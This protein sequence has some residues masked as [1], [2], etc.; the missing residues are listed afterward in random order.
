MSSPR[1]S[2]PALVFT[3]LTV[4]AVTVAPDVEPP[5]FTAGDAIRNRNGNLRFFFWLPYVSTCLLSR[6]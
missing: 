3:F 2:K 5:T 4:A 6:L 1:L